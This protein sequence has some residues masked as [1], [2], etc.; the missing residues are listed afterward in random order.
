[1]GQDI[2]EITDG[3]DY[4]PNEVRARWIEAAGG[5]RKL[6]LRLDLGVFQME[7]DGRPDGTQPH[8]YPSLLEY[9][10]A[11]ERKRTRGVLAEPLDADACSELQ[12]EAMQYYYRIMACHAL[13][14]WIRVR[15]DSDHA[16]DLIDL[17]SE[18]AADDETAWHFSQMF[19]YMRMMNARALA[20][21]AMSEGN[22][23]EAA[24]QAQ[25]AVEEIE[26]FYRENYDDINEDGSEVATPG[27]LV[28]VRELLAEVEKRR[29]VTETE[30]L[31]RELA[32]AIELENYER[33]AQLRDKLKGLKGFGH[34]V[35]GGAK[36]RPR[37]GGGGSGE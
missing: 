14:E 34:T 5:G 8:R 1:M 18:Y 21:I 2:A 16:L 30:T 32:R 11:E 3:W 15:D 9:Y 36:K 35:R 31:Q 17:A 19:P 27:E 12:Q 7:S 10:L 26:G 22:Y 25:E 20:E 37:A 6:Q 23:A 13:G 24:R 29:P 33:A 4:D 28:S